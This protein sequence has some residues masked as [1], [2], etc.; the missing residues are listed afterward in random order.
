MQS[1]NPETIPNKFRLV[2]S[3]HRFTK[4]IN[5]NQASPIGVQASGE[6]LKTEKHLHAASDRLSFQVEVHS[7][8]LTSW[9]CHSKSS[10]RTIGVH[11]S[12]AVCRTDRKDREIFFEGELSANGNRWFQSEIQTGTAPA[13]LG[14][15]ALCQTVSDALSLS[16][17]LSLCSRL[18]VLDSPCPTLCDS[19]DGACL[20]ARHSIE[21]YVCLF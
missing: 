4:P 21:L 19:I 18:A 2:I 14:V 16:L 15:L 7:A 10:R 5:F 12:A 17:S 11:R 8:W 1:R 6:P 3:N 20:L 9:A 13:V